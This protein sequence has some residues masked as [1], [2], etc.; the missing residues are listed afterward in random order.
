MGLS[1]SMYMYIGSAETSHRKISPIIRWTI[2]LP[3]EENW[4]EE[5]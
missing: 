2:F 3:R 4:V 5:V 1:M